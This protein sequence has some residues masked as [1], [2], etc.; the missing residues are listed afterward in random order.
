MGREIDMENDERAQPSPVEDAL[1][2]ESTGGTDRRDMRRDR[3]AESSVPDWIQEV[4]RRPAAAKVTR[5]PPIN[6]MKEMEPYNIEE[7]MVHI[8]PEITFPQLLDVSPRLRQE[9]A[10][11]LRSS[12]PRTRKEKHQWK[13]KSTMSMDQ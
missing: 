1:T 10:L 7:A 12:Q 5:P 3:E 2:P 13:R 11:L 4:C 8:K 9:L 6:L